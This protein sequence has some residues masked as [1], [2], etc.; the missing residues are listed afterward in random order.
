MN[1]TL[2][3]GEKCKELTL[4]VLTPQVTDERRMFSWKILSEA[5]TIRLFHEGTMR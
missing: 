4:F 5:T 1:P 3:L 2:V